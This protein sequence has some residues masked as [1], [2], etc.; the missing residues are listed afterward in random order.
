MRCKILHGASCVALQSTI[1]GCHVTFNTG[2]ACAFK[3]KDLAKV[4]TERVYQ[5]CSWGCLFDKSVQAKVRDFIRR[6]VE[7]MLP[8]TFMC[9]DFPVFW[10]QGGKKHSYRFSQ[11]RFTIHSS[12]RHKLLCRKICEAATPSFRFELSALLN[13]CGCCR[14]YLRY[15]AVLSANL[16][17]LVCTP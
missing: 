15:L 13:N 16:C 3:A 8:D 4:E 9:P 14:W 12:W 1:M 2:C 11:S 10:G 6:F 5:L 7:R 17:Q